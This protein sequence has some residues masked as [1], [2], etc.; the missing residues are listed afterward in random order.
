MNFENYT[1]K[2]IFKDT[3][4]KGH[5]EGLKDQPMQEGTRELRG[6]K[7]WSPYTN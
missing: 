4:E 1:T 3:F 7:Q 5:V 6:K 2:T